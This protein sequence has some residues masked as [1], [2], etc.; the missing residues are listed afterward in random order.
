MIL[1]AG[2]GILTG[3]MLSWRLSRTNYGALVLVVETIVLALVAAAHRFDPEI[4][5]ICAVFWIAVQATW[6]VA[7]LLTERDS[8]DP[9]P[10]TAAEPN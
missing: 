7:A 3:W 8:P 10:E 6:F 5:A 2:A 1:W 4:L 9:T